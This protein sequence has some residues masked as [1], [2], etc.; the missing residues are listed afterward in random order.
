[1]HFTFLDDDTLVFPHMS[2]KTLEISKIIPSSNSEEAPELKTLY[3]LKLPPMN[4]HASIVRMSCR[5]EPTP[6]GRASTPAVRARARRP[7]R[8]APADAIIIFDL[9]VQDFSPLVLG[10]ITA[11]CFVVHRRA[12]LA[13]VRPAQLDV[14]ATPDTVEWAA[15]GPRATRWFDGDELTMRWITTTAGQRYVSMAAAEL[16]PIRVRDFNPHAVRRAG[17]G[18]EAVRLPSGNTLR[19]VTG[20]S[21]ITS[22]DLFQDDLESALPYVETVTEAEYSYDGVLMDEERILGLKVCT[23]WIA[24]QVS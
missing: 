17:A 13:H 5:G 21:V 24:R 15:W 11:F 3:I 8:D 1:M 14:F 16:A 6:M 23:L 22:S 9:L 20:S 7:F 18:G 12:L 2:Q 4:R 10:H 19:V